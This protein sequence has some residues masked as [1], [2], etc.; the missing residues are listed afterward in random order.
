MIELLLLVAA[1]YF[2]VI[3]LA[4]LILAIQAWRK[5]NRAERQSREVQRPSAPTAQVSTRTTAPERP[6]PP[7]APAPSTPKASPPPAAAV[8]PPVVPTVTPTPA[9]APPPRRRAP[10]PT[11]E[12]LPEAE[13]PDWTDKLRGLGLWPPTAVGQARETV[14]MQW[15][16]PRLGGLLAILTAIF[17][18]VYIG[19]YS[20]PSIRFLQLVGV[21][22]GML[23]GGHW[24]ERKQ[25][26]F[27]YVVVVTGLILIYFAAAAGYLLPAVRI[28]GDLQVGLALQVA[29]L[30]LVLGVALRRNSEPL[31]LL[32]LH[33]GIVLAVFMAWQNMREGA[34]ITM[35]LLTLLGYGLA[36]WKRWGRLPWVLVPGLFAVVAVWPI[37]SWVTTVDPPSALVVLIYLNGALALSLGLLRSEKLPL[38]GR[39]PTLAILAAS[40]L[41]AVTLVFLRWTDASLSSLTYGSL[42]GHLLLWAWAFR[43]RGPSRFMGLEASLLI[44]LFLIDLL[45]GELRWL[46]LGLQGILLAVVARTDRRLATE[47]V[48]LATLAAAAYYFAIP[49]LEGESVSRLVWW[50]QC[51]FPLLLLIA[52]SQVNGRSAG[53]AKRGASGGGRKG[54]Y[55]LLTLG[56]VWMWVEV[57]G[58]ASAPGID[59]SLLLAGL[60][61]A[62]VVPAFL[63]GANARLPA[64]AGLAL[65][66]VAAVQLI[67]RPFV[68]PSLLVLLVWMAGALWAL[69]HREGRSTTVVETVVVGLWMTASVGVILAQTEHAV[70]IAGLVLAVGFLALGAG[71]TRIPKHWA[72][73]SGIPLLVLLVHGLPEMAVALQ[74]AFLVGAL[75]LV[76]ATGAVI[77]T[78][79]SPGWTGRLQLWTWISAVPLFFI[80]LEFTG[81]D[82]WILRHGLLVGIALVLLGAGH[83]FHLGGWWTVG[84]GLLILPYL[85]HFPLSGLPLDADRPWFG[86]SLI[87]ALLLIAA[88]IVWRWA[89]PRGRSPQLG[90]GTDELLDTAAAGLSFAGLALLCFDR[91]FPLPEFVTALLAVHALV[92]V[93][94]G[95]I[96]RLRGFRIGGLLLL[97]I[98]LIRLFAIDLQDALYRI[99]GFAV[100][101]ACLMLAGYLYHRLARRL[102]KPDDERASHAEDP[103]WRDNG[104]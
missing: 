88:P 92:L 73:L 93:W 50:F 17:F 49:L 76:L 68:I 24:L 39:P 80:G 62:A 99:V 3:P 81:P 38:R 72:G 95:F 57:S 2:L 7:P 70:W 8:P 96:A 14:L 27:G 15:W 98:P 63:P 89:L 12:A 66:I 101:A 33:F 87:S 22:L 85:Q 18:S 9:P 47:G 36:L 90:S 78:L 61:F 94:L 37:L 67:E 42:G 43:G 26:A 100:A 59:R 31:V 58:S 32:A 53:E 64:L 25:P 46:T 30:L 104:G 41:A 11:P 13:G 51:L 91:A 34:L 69:R 103:A 75:G 40:L 6:S 55:A 5:A 52:F 84:L 60:A 65:Y 23:V 102:E 71:L 29:A 21:A 16:L 79:P 83:R 97:L 45:T 77:R 1:V 35:A 82:A 56:L 48:L 74:T 54:L 28:T 19:R 86:E 20:N 44:S 10:R 4:A